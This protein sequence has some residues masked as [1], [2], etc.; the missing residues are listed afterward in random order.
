MGYLCKFSTVAARRI[1]GPPA[2]NRHMHT[3][4]KPRASNMAVTMIPVH[5][6]VRLGCLFLSR[7]QAPSYLVICYPS[8]IEVCEQNLQKVVSTFRSKK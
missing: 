3:Y 8:Q 6:I 7:S 2:V 4:E 1:N 5:V